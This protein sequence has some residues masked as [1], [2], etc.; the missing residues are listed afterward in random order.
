VV[1]VRE[2]DPRLLQAVV[3]GVEGKLV[4]RERDGALRVLDVR[5]ALLL[6]G[7]DDPAVLDETGR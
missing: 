5:E 3:D 2:D 7:G 4:G 1:N 6:G